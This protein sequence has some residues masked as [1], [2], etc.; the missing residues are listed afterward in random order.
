MQA[1]DR[2]V[3]GDMLGE[4]LNS[5]IMDNTQRY[6]KLFSQAAD[7]SM[8]APDPDTIASDILDVIQFQRTEKNRENGELGESIFPP[9]LLRR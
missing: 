3:P 5:R 9:N 7:E 2:D 1:S 8:P 6:I 4:P